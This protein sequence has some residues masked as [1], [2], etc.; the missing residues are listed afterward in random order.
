MFLKDR[1]KRDQIRN[2]WLGIL[3][4]QTLDP[5]TL[6]PQNLDPQILDHQILDPQI[7]DLQ[8]LDPHRHVPIQIRNP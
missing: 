5:Q 8:I 4:A 6:D 7:I 1:H 2:R 3:D